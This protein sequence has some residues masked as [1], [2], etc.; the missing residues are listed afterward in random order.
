[1]LYTPNT[2]N[3]LH[4]KQTMKDLDINLQSFASFLSGRDVSWCKKLVARGANPNLS[5]KEG[6]HP[7]HLAAYSGNPEIL[8]YLM[9]CNSRNRV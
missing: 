6:W 3:A 7:M 1:V 8:S 9:K 2:V 4:A 5:N